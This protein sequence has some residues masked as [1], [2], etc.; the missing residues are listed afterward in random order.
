MRY[1]L[2]VLTH[3]ADAPLETSLASFWERVSPWPS[4]K[5]IVADGMEA[6]APTFGDDEMPWQAHVLVPQRGFCGAVSALWDL[7][8]E[9][10]T[11]YVF[12]LEHDFV[13]TRDLDLRQLADVLDDFPQLAQMHLIREPVNERERRAGGIWNLQP[14][15]YEPRGEWM[16][17]R[18]YFTTNPSLMR[19]QFMRENRWTAETVECEGKFGWALRE[20]GY[21]SGAWGNGEAWCEHIGVRTGFGY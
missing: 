21:S 9:A 17:H 11:D 7:A 13:F 16:E 19:T 18:I 1:T 6:R 2:A 15:D 8:A 4:E 12:W 3:G 10:D 14:D 5:V 20:Q